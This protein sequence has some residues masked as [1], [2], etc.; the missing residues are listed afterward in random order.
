MLQRLLDVNPRNIYLFGL[1]GDLRVEAGLEGVSALHLTLLTLS[2]V[3]AHD[4]AVFTEGG[5][6]V[7]IRERRVA[8]LEW[9]L[10]YS[11]ERVEV[12]IFKTQVVKLNKNIKCQASAI[13]LYSFVC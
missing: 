3:L 13:K 10:E 7:I 5:L 12:I 1:Y 4:G 9:V 2:V 8:I 11:R 6:E